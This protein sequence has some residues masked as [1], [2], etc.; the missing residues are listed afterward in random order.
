MDA[1][2]SLQ[3]YIAVAGLSAIHAG[4]CEACDDIL[5]KISRFTLGDMK[6][7]CIIHNG[8]SIAMA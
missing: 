3:G 2:D 8:I 4:H 7:N 5:T 1:M 6:E